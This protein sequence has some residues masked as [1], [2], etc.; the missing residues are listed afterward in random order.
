M[1]SPLNND[2]LDE[3]ARRRVGPEE[4]ARWRRELASRPAEV[5]RLD[6]ELALNEALDRSPAPR[7]SSNFTARVLDEIGRDP[8]RESFLGRL[9]HRFGTVRLPLARL[10]FAGT[11]AVALVVGWH[12]FEARQNVLLARNAAEISEAV[13]VPGVAVLR[14]FEAV[15][16]LDTKSSPDDVD[17]IG[18]LRENEP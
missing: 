17:L 8:R 4:A 6:E 16:L 14:D 2:W 5:R 7:P 15:Q 3:A 18:A 11:A 9:F 13:S 12:R 1:H 10:A